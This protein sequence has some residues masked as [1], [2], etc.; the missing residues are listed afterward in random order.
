[1]VLEVAPNRWEIDLGLDASRFEHVVGTDPAPLEELRGEDG[2]GRQN[3]LLPREEL[4]SLV[5]GAIEGLDAYRDEGGA[6][7]GSVEQDFSA[8][9][10]RLELQ[11]RTGG[12]LVVV[13][14]Q[15]R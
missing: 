11:V 15:R 12:D 2:P 3:Y 14:V 8:L 5:R 1:M 13:G 6:T 7:I 4:D 10:Q 9:V